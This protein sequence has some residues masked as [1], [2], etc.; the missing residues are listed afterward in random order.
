MIVGFT[1][2][3]NYANTNHSR[4]NPMQKNAAINFNPSLN[5]P[6]GQKK[7]T[8]V[9]INNKTIEQEANKS[10]RTK[11]LI[12]GTILSNIFIFSLGGIGPINERI[13]FAAKYS[14]KTLTQRLS[15]VPVFAVTNSS[16]QP[17]LTSNSKGEQVGLIFFSHEDAVN[18]LKEMQETHQVSDAR[19][20]IMGLDKA[21][22]MVSSNATPSG[23][24][25]NLGQ[26]LKMVF[27]F[28][29]DQKELKN[30][31][32][33]S[34]I[35][36]LKDK[37][38]GLPVFIADGLTIRKGKEDIIP[39]FFSKNDLENAWSLMC[40]SNPDQIKKPE[41]KVGDLLSIIKQMENDEL[42]EYGFF[43]SSES[44]E[45]VKSENRKI[46]SAKIHSNSIQKF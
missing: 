30:V 16:G 29:P 43:P 34:G 6:L 35:S 15:Q 13:A 5:C 22:K 31:T 38:D 32:S 24:K 19:I 46:P 28:Y 45:F 27:R 9:K 17:Y 4:F 14:A 39:I 26:E 20:Y 40:E 1:Y 7:L 21:F 33:V 41:I 23:I 10:E 42:Q 3:K 44:I 12:Y 18:L 25:G 37:F 2:G 11:I 36:V 8:K